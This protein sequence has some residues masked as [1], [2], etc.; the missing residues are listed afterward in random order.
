MKSITCLTC[1]F[2]L[3]P[4]TSIPRWKMDGLSKS[5]RKFYDEQVAARNAELA[6]GRLGYLG[7]SQFCNAQ[8]AAIFGRTCVQLFTHCDHI[9]L[10]SDRR[11]EMVTKLASKIYEWV[12]KRKSK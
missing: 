8:C 11:I 7:E 4:P 10:E 9:P 12:A 6:D 2:P 1:E 5:S 3:K